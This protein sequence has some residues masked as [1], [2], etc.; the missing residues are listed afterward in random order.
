MGEIPSYAWII[1]SCLG[2]FKA[3]KIIVWLLIEASDESMSLVRH[4]RGHYL[5][6]KS[7]KSEEESRLLSKA[8]PKT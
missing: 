7:W 8:E 4:V 6:I 5:E 3:Y 2:I 1:L